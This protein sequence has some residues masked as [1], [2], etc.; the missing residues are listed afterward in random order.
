M[1]LCLRC[2][3]YSRDACPRTKYIVHHI[4]RR[5]V[6]FTQ[7]S[8]HAHRHHWLT[9]V[10]QLRGMNIEYTGRMTSSWTGFED[11]S[12]ESIRSTEESKRPAESS[13]ILPYE[14]QGA[15]EL[16]DMFQRSTRK[17]CIGRSTSNTRSTMLLISLRKSTAALDRCRVM[18]HT[19]PLIYNV[20]TSVPG[21]SNLDADRPRP[22][23]QQSQISAPLPFDARSSVRHPASDI[24]H[25]G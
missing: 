20:C 4:G 12:K 18:F 9:E 17:L 22:R 16:R 2:V 8:C 10:R 14:T 1:A 3:I 24:R 7:P 19:S 5:E 15:A 11:A 23:P 13:P 6:D 21:A 25:P